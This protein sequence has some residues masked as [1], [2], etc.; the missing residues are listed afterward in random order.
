VISK[1]EIFREKTCLNKQGN[2]RKNNSRKNGEILVNICGMLDNNQKR[3]FALKT[4]HSNLI[5]VHE[6]V[7]IKVGKNENS[8]KGGIRY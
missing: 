2:F 7:G 1:Y 3:R 5:F 8:F 6:L 4:N